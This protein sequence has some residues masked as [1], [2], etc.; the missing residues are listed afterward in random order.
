MDKSRQLAEELLMDWHY[1]TTAWR[2]NLGYPAESPDFKQSKSSRQWDCAN[3]IVDDLQKREEIKAVQYCYD[4]IE[5]VYQ[6]AIGCELKNR[7]AGVSG[8]WRSKMGKT[9][10]DAMQQIIPVMIRRGLL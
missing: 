2:P 9:F 3:D 6:N 1:H 4:A 7:Y 8:V 10:D 5:Y